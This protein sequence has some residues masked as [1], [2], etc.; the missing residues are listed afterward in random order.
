MIT[1]VLIDKICGEVFNGAKSLLK[2]K[3][4][5]IEIKKNDLQESLSDHYSDVISWMNFINFKELRSPKNLESVYVD[6]KIQLTPKRWLP[7]DHS[8]PKFI[9]EDLINR[10]FHLIILGDVGAGKTTTMKYVCKQLIESNNENFS[11]YGFPIRILLRNL[12]QSQSIFDKLRQILGIQI[13]YTG[14]HPTVEEE[15]Y[16][17]KKEQTDVTRKVVIKYL[18]ELKPLIIIDGFDEINEAKQKELFVELNELYLKNIKAKVILTCRSAEFEIDLPNSEV[19]EICP[20]NEI[21]I[22]AFVYNWLDE[23]DYETQ[24]F[25]KQLKTT[26]FEDAAIRPLTLAHL[27][28]LYRKYKRIPNQPKS[29]YKRIVNLLIEDWDVQRGITRTSSFSNFEI[30]KKLDFLYSLAYEITIQTGEKTFNEELLLSIF[31]KIHNN[32]QISKIE[33]RKVIKEIESETGLIIKTSHDTF[34]FAHSSIQEYLTAEYIVKLPKVYKFEIDNYN[35][36]NE[37]AITI[38]LSSNPTLYFASLVIDT[39]H[40]IDLTEVKISAF[41]KRLINENPDFSESPQTAT[42]IFAIYTRFFCRKK[43]NEYY[44]KKDTDSFE[45]F[46]NSIITKTKVQNSILGLKKYYWKSKR[47]NGLI[48]LKREGG[49]IITGFDYPDIL[50]ISENYYDVE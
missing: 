45:L 31:D 16:Q 1:E 38:C 23:D 47:E 36:M 21:Q 29:I 7:T 26:P 37:L 44:P 43:N 5:K 35:L 4:Y 42:G 9:I 34:E 41:L 40:D 48:V 11:T 3:D 2:N 28:A 25:I 19:F 27:C 14:R 49:N 18:E 6:L 17:Q 13:Y 50:V 22:K 12:G 10:D 32:F 24:T 30:D 39:F 46:Y 15:R 20:L 8:E 33:R